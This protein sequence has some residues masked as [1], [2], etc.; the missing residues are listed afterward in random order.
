MFV[1]KGSGIYCSVFHIVSKVQEKQWFVVVSKIS[2]TFTFYVN[3]TKN[4]NFTPLNIGKNA[5]DIMM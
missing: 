1:G 2:L 4:K 3:V 5:Q